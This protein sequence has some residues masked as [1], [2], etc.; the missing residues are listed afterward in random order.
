MCRVG[1]RVAAQRRRQRIA[2][3]LQ[4]ECLLDVRVRDQLRPEVVADQRIDARVGIGAV[5]ERADHRLHDV[6]GDELDKRS[7][8]DRGEVEEDFRRLGNAH[9]RPEIAHDGRAVRVQNLALERAEA[10]RLERIFVAFWRRSAE[11]CAISAAMPRSCDALP[12]GIAI[13]S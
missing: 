3:R 10:M 13:R 11:R 4:L 7:G 8:R 9:Q 2:G 12:S 6:V 1:D 5:G